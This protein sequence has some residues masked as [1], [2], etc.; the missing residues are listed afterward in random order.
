MLMIKNTDDN[1]PDRI[2]ICLA[3]CLLFALVVFGTTVLNWLGYVLFLRHK[4]K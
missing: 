2:R 1:K 4:I 3:L